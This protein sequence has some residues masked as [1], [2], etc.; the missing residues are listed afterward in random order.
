[1]KAEIDKEGILW[2]IAKTELESYALA[3]W[4]WDNKITGT[5]NIILDWWLMEPSND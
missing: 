2:I 1:M 5:E 3:K 4:N